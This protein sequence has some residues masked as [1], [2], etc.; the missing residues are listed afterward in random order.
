MSAAYL[1]A[2]RSGG[3]LVPRV[4]L[5]DEDDNETDELTGAD[6]WVI[7]ADVLMD[8]TRAPRRTVSMTL[9]NPD[10]FWTPKALSGKLWIQ[11]RFKIQ[12][13]VRLRS[14][15]VEYAT[16]GQFVVDRPRAAFTGDD[17]TLAVQGSDYWRLG[18]ERKLRQAVIFEQSQRL[19]E[20]VTTLGPLAGFPTARMRLDDS[21]RTLG[22]RL[23]LP[24]GSAIMP[25]LAKIVA[26]YAHEVYADFDGYLVLAPAPT[27][28][29]MAEPVYSLSEGEDAILLGVTKDWNADSLHNAVAVIGEG[30]QRPTVSGEARDLNPESPAYN[31]A[32][33][34][35]PAWPNG[36]GPLGDRL[37]VE[38]TGRLA[39]DH[40]CYLRAQAILFET[41]MLEETYDLSLSPLAALVPGDVVRLYHPDS[42]SDDNLLIDSIRL[43]TREDADQA[44]GIKKLRRLS[45][46]A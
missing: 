6:G 35:D 22:T 26:D 7:D 46:P 42:D 17:A 24:Y 41:S 29:D 16:L 30:A 39:D 18:H 1:E 25:E 34:S 33:G 27:G 3:E 32:P 40:A 43:G 11:K 13:G 2:I 19:E 9:A 45:P 36:G 14:G 8:R 31:P 12:H 23:V 10:G 15:V 44:L 21:S 38:Y 37:L 20:V 28:E 4:T 5:L